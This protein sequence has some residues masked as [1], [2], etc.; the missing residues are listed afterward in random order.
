MIQKGLFSGEHEIGKTSGY[1]FEDPL[2]GRVAG[3]DL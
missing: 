1:S 3:F 2:V